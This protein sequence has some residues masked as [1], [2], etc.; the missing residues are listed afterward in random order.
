MNSKAAFQSLKTLA[1][2]GGDVHIYMHRLYIIWSGLYETVVAVLH[3]WTREFRGRSVYRY[4]RNVT[5]SRNNPGEKCSD[6]FYK[7]CRK[8]S[9]ATFEFSSPP[10][11]RVVT[12]LGDGNNLPLLERQITG[13]RNRSR[14]ISPLIRC[15]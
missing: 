1:V 2:N 12:L 13:L 11:V 6:H 3:N 8:Y 4:R 14:N 5:H 7:I 9:A 10:C 15:E